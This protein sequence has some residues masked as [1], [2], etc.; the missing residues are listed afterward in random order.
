MNKAH[1]CS[2]C[3]L[4]PA[5]AVMAATPRRPADFKTFHYEYTTEQW[6]EKFSSD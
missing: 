6:M 2:I 1:I 3:L 5:V 4:S